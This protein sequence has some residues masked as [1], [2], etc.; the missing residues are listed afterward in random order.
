MNAIIFHGTDCKPED[1]W[2]QWLKTQ[3]EARG[4][5]V[6]LP[7]YPEMNHV[8]IDEYIEKILKAHSFDEETVLIGHSSGGSLIL[9][10]LERIEPTVTQ[11]ILVAGFSE[12]LDHEGGE[13]I[14]LQPS[15]NWEKIKAH[16]KDFVFINSDNDPWGCDD[17]QGRKLFD[18]L[19]GTQVICHDGHFGSTA[20]NQP[21]KEFPLLERLITGD[22]Q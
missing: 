13:D 16:A 15:Y 18:K 19:G 4:F 6:E 22:T 3:L 12:A 20:K 10:I 11:A 7:Y 8:P 21:Y 14:I 17:K 9:S 1:F 2:Y 5:N